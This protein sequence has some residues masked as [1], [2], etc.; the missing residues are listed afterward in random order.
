MCSTAI[1]SLLLVIAATLL[2]ISGG[3]GGGCA[4]FPKVEPPLL[5]PYFQGAFTELYSTSTK[6]PPYVNGVPPDAT[7]NNGHVYYDAEHTASGAMIEHRF[8]SCI[9]IFPYATNFSCTFLNVNG[10]TYLLSNGSSNLPDCCVFASP[11]HPPRRDFLRKMET[12]DVAVNVPWANRTP[13]NL[14]LWFELPSINP[15]TGPFWYSFSQQRRANAHA[16]SESGVL[17]P[18]QVYDSFSFPGMPPILMVQ[19]NF[20]SDLSIT[21][22]DASVWTIP[23]MCRK[24]NIPNC[25]FFGVD[26]KLYSMRGRTN[27]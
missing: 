2:L 5:P 25:H 16:E 22:P 3:D 6:V 1:S 10:E 20:A 26:E 21:K 8:P 4:A 15:P 27:K 19:Q 17:N 12:L 11:W 23:E 18:V 14:S 7:V 9:P 24:S 13:R